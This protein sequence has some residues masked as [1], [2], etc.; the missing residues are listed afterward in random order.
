[1]DEVFAGTVRV[2]S[3]M[4]M[5]VCLEK[6][7][8]KYAAKIRACDR[9]WPVRRAFSNRRNAPVHRCLPK[10][11]FSFEPEQKKPGKGI[12]KAVRFV[13]TAFGFFP[14]PQRRCS[15]YFFTTSS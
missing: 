6:K 11:V 1:V 5:T 13:R 15:A 8:G 7:T 14:L 9:S 12:K 10:F 3:M 2:T 4:S